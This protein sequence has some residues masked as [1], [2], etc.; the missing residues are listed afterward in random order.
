VH[1]GAIIALSIPS[2]L[3]WLADDE[4]SRARTA[5]ARALRATVYDGVRLRLCLRL[6]PRASRSRGGG[7]D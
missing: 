1:D 2:R 6:R 4:V 5:R 7:G 3:A